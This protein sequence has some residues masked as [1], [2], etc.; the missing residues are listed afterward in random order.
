[1]PPLV[2]KLLHILLGSPRCGVYGATQCFSHVSVQNNSSQVNRTEGCEGKAVPGL[3]NLLF[4]DPFVLV[5]RIPVIV[6]SEP[7]STASLKTL[8]PGDMGLY[9]KAAWSSSIGV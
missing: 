5:G 7:Y 2:P 8:V 3:N 6:K 4:F 9:Q 1:M